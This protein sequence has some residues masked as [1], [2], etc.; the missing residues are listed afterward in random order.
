MSTPREVTSKKILD[1]ENFLAKYKKTPKTRR[2]Y[3]GGEGELV[4]T[5]GAPSLCR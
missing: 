4:V 3:I 5:C 1:I 2:H